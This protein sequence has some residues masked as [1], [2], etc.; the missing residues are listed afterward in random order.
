MSFLEAA[1]ILKVVLVEREAE[2]LIMVIEADGRIKSLQNI[3]PKYGKNLDL[4][5]R[6]KSQNKSKSVQRQH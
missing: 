4:L 2:Y 1:L 3:K 5:S 6:H